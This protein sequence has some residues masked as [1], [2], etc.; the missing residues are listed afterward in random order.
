M[1]QGETSNPTPHCTA[2]EC[3]PRLKPL[4]CE[5]QSAEEWSAVCSGL[6]VCSADRG[7]WP[8]RNKISSVKK[9]RLRFFVFFNQKKT[10][11][12]A[13]FNSHKKGKEPHPGLLHCRTFEAIDSRP[14]SRSRTQKCA[15]L[16]PGASLVHVRIALRAGFCGFGHQKEKEKG[17]Y[18]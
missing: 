18:N 15:T 2:T 4:V 8:Y 9:A 16:G 12:V 17:D 14:I 5:R 11:Q 6:F 10:A 13:W 7:H 1:R 3:M